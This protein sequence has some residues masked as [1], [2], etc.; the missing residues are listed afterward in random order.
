M[1]LSQDI[2]SMTDFARGTKEHLAEITKHNRPRVLTQNGKAA[3]VV[4]SVA[5]YEEIAHQAEEYRLDLELKAALEAY[6]RGDRGT[7]GPLAF[8]SLREETVRRRASR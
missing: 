6:D 2:V 8:Q 7:P 1:I 5:C 4:L 3:A